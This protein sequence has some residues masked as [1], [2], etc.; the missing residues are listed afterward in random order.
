[1][2]VAVVVSNPFRGMGLCGGPTIGPRLKLWTDQKSKIEEIVPEMARRRAQMWNN[3]KAGELDP[4]DDV[5]RRCKKN[6]LSV[7][8]CM[9]YF[10][11]IRF[12]FRFIKRTKEGCDHGSEVE[13]VHSRRSGEEPVPLRKPKE[14]GRRENDF[15]SR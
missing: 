2:V 8:S 13:T 5:R 12:S 10:R 1:M 3:P 9:F 14:S 11:F 4:A 7:L 6:S 15:V